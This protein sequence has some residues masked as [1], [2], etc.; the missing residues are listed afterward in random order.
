[1]LTRG[2]RE[3]LKCVS[4]SQWQWKGW[5]ML[6]PVTA[7]ESGGAV[8]RLNIRLVGRHYSSVVVRVGGGW[9]VGGGDALAV[10]AE[11][12]SSAHHMWTCHKPLHQPLTPEL[13]QQSIKIVRSRE[14]QDEN[15][16]CVKGGSEGLHCS[17][18]GDYRNIWDLAVSWRTF[19]YQTDIV[20]STQWAAA[21]CLS[22]TNDFP[23]MPYVKK[24]NYALLEP[25]VR[26]MLR[27]VLQQIDDQ[28]MICSVAPTWGVKQKT[29][30]KLFGCSRLRRK[31]NNIKWNKS[32]AGVQPIGNVQCLLE[33]LIP[34]VE[35]HWGKFL[36]S[37]ILL[38]SVKHDW[39]CIHRQHIMSQTSIKTNEESS[40]L[41]M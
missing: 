2:W 11:H 28:H 41:R 15:R 6:Q 14:R 12:H 20:L 26:M 4:A 33:I 30:R 17:F 8:K 16:T 36:R 31:K 21:L 37:L 22:F 34:P 40:P 39:Q 38:A 3:L 35:T 9:E 23:N 25:T 32:I 24:K 27:C 19:Y 13:M 1:M 7:W 18:D 5:T 10:W 29:N